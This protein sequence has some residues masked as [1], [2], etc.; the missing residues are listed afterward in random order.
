MA[1]PII[2]GIFGCEDLVIVTDY[3]SVKVAEFCNHYVLG[4]DPEDVELA[5]GIRGAG[6]QLAVESPEERKVD[7]V[8]SVGGHHHENRPLLETVHEGEDQDPPLHLEVGRLLLDGVLLN[9]EHSSP[10]NTVMKAKPLVDQ[11]SFGRKTMKNKSK[12]QE[13]QCCICGKLFRSAKLHNMHVYKYHPQVT[14]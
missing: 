12:I 7:G 9:G 11:R 14:E 3:S 6:V 5:H 13:P 1:L 2:K 8:G 10:K 4:L